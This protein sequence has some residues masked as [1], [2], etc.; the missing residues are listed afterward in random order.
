MDDKLKQLQRLYEVHGPGLL[1]YLRRVSGDAQL[2]EDLLQ[3]VFVRVMRRSEHDSDIVSP[4]AWL[5]AIARNLSL[6]VYRRRRSLSP[7]P[8]QL[9]SPCVVEEDPHLA[10]MRR[11]IAALPE[12]QRIVLEHRVQ[13]GLTYEEI[14]VVLSIPV[15]TVRS[16]IHHAMRKLR[17]ELVTAE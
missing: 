2:A 11:A 13:E 3:G 15:G 17:D 7:L 12:K 5:F 6:D 14:A 4:R 10:S 8:E 9:V 16:R 1:R